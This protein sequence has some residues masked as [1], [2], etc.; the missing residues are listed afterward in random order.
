MKQET[1][2]NKQE[3]QEENK[4]KNDPIPDWLHERAEDFGKRYV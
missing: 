1:N 2:E 4:E 3:T